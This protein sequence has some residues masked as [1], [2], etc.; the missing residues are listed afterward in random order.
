MGVSKTKMLILHITGP[1][2]PDLDMVDLPGLVSTH[3]RQVTERIFLSHIEH[4]GEPENMRALT[5]DLVESYVKQNNPH[6]LY[7]IAVPATSAPNQSLAF[8]IVQKMGLHDK[9]I[10][11]F[12]WNREDEFMLRLGVFTKSDKCDLKDES[13]GVG[14]LRDLRSKVFR[15]YYLSRYWCVGVPASARHCTTRAVGLC[16]YHEST[17]R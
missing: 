5:A 14:G 12:C 1:N 6:S 9:S 10:G 7:L 11:E 15:R 4:S 13:D 8:E 3:V 17:T 2:C 16:V